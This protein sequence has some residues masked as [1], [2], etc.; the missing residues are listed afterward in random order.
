MRFVYFLLTLLIL[1]VT[2]L[3]FGYTHTG[4]AKASDDNPAD[5]GTLL[6]VTLLVL[7]LCVLAVLRSRGRRSFSL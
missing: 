7:L 3:A 5:F 1:T 2:C 4:A 6:P